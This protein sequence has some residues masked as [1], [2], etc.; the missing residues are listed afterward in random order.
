MQELSDI[1]QY[2]PAG[3]KIVVEYQERVSNQGIILPPSSKQ[4]KPGWFA[5]VIAI[6]PGADLKDAGCPDLKPGDV[7]DTDCMR[8]HCRSFE[9]GGKIFLL[10]N[11][12]DVVGIV[13]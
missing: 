7:I 10:I 3:H 1:K 11:D 6:S 4:K 2:Q 12:G 5:T 8:E 13:K 9:I